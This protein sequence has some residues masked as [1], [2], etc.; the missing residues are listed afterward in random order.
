[1][2]DFS[3]FKDLYNKD[4]EDETEADFEKSNLYDI[5]RLQI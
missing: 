5:K 2:D 3:E 4:K 1:M